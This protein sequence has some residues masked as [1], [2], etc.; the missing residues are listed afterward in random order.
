MKSG[1]FRFVSV[2][3]LISLLLTSCGS[4]ISVAEPAEPVHSGSDTAPSVDLSS[5]PV[6]LTVSPKYSCYD[7]APEASM[8]YT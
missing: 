5:A 6:T 1:F 7:L 3:V 8:R 4:Q 2:F